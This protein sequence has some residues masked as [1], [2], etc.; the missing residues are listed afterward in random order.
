MDKVQKTAFTDYKS[1]VPGYFLDGTMIM[2]AMVKE[3]G[4]SGMNL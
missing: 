4:S 2:N 3:T 1:T